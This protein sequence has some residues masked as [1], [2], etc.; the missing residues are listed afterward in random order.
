MTATAGIPSSAARND[1]KHPN[2]TGKKL[3]YN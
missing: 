3:F 2:Y 1:G